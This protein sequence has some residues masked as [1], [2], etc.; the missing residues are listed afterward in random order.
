MGCLGGVNLGIIQWIILVGILAF[1]IK[2][3]MPVKGVSQMTVA[4][5]KNKLKDTNVQ[6]IDVRTP[7]EYRSNHRKPFKNIPLS[8]LASQTNKLDANKEVVVICQSGM[9]SMK[10]AKVLKKHG[11]D[12]VINVKGGMNAWV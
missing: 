5:V 8:Q 12:H 2:Q 3:F 11:F 7:Q 6:F 1:A 10:A 9:R 4:D